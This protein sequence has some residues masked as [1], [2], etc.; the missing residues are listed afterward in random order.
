M[1]TNA[2]KSIH[3]EI[4][5]SKS[6]KPSMV[7][8]LRRTSFHLGI[9]Q[10]PEVQQE[11][12]DIPHVA[13]AAPDNANWR[14]ADRRPVT[15]Y[16]WLCHICSTNIQQIS[17]KA[18]LNPNFTLC[19]SYLLKVVWRLNGWLRLKRDF[20]AATQLRLY[21]TY[22]I[23]IY[24][25]NLHLCKLSVNVVSE[26]LLFMSGMSVSCTFCQYV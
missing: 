17:N 23:I 16:L 19:Y 3:A 18:Q 5:I 11:R 24:Y 13:V 14:W 9:M 2:R 1:H 26:T 25:T 8:R 22:R 15:K 4:G 6:R 7:Q 20:Q 21:R 12:I 10:R